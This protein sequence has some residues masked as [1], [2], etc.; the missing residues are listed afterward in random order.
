MLI[1]RCVGVDVKDYCSVCDAEISRESKTI[2]AKGHTSSDWITDKAATC[3]ETG[4]RHKE[5][6]VCG[7]ILDTETVAKLTTHTPATAVT[8]NRVDATCTKAGSYDSVVYCSVC[9]AEISRE[10]KTIAKKA[11]TSSDWITDKEP[12]YTEAGSRH[13]ECTVCGEILDTETMNPLE[14]THAFGEWSVSKV[15]TCT[16]AG[17]KV[18]VCVC[19]QKETEA[20]AAKGHTSSDWITDKQPTCKEAGSRHTECTVCGAVLKT[21]TVAK[22]TTHPPAAAVTENRVDAT[23]T[24]AGS[25]DSVIY[26][27]VCDAE[28]SRESKTIAKKEHTP[29]DWMVDKAATCKEAGSRHTECTVCEAVLKTESI[30]KLTTHTP[31]TAVTENKVD[32]TCTKAGSY[33]SVIYC[34]VCDAEISRESKTIA[35]KAHTPSDWITDKAATCKETGSRHTE[36]TVCGEILDT[37]T[38][39]KLTTHTPATAVTENRVDATCTKAG[40]YDSVVY[41]SVCD[42]E[43]SRE[44]KT[45]AKKAHTSSGWITD[46]EPTYTEAGARH[47]ECTVCKT[48]LESGTIAKLDP[49]VYTVNYTVG[50]QSGSVDV[51]IIDSFTLPVV[52][53]EGYTFLGYYDGS[54]QITDGE[55]KKLASYTLTSDISI[56]AKYRRIAAE[57]PYHGECVGNPGKAYYS[58][59]SFAYKMARNPWDMILYNGKLYV[60]GGYLDVSWI[61]SPPLSSYDTGTNA[62]SYTDFDVKMYEAFDEDSTAKAW[63]DLPAASSS[64]TV[65][66]GSIK[67][68]PVSTDKEIAGFRWIGGKPFAIGSD[69]LGGYTWADGTLDQKTPSEVDASDTQ[70][71]IANTSGNY[72]AVETDESGNDVW[73]EYRNSIMHGTQVYDVIEIDYNGERTLMF[74]VGTGGLQLPVKILSSKATKSYLTPKFYLADGTQ[75]SGSS[76]NRVYHFFKTDEGIFAFYSSQDGTVNKIFKYSVVGNEHRFDEVRDVT[77]GATSADMRVYLQSDVDKNGT[78]IADRR[79]FTDYMRTETYGGYA[80]YTTGYLYKTKTFKESETAAI[81][82]PGGAIITDLLVKDGTLYVLGFKETDVGSAYTNYVWSLG[83]D[84]T[85]TEVRSFTSEGAYALS[86]EKDG[87][88]F[89]VGLGGPSTHIT[90]DVTSVG[91]IVRLAA[92]EHPHTFGEWSTDK[93]ATCTEAG[94]RVR[95]CECGKQEIEVIPMSGHTS[96]G[97][98][99]DKAATCKEAGSRHTECTVC[100]A[101]LK[102]ESI[103]KLTTHTPATAVTENKVDATCTK[104]GSYDSVIYCSVCDAEISRESKTIAKKAHTSSGWITD[105]DPTYTEEG[106]RHKECT[107]C[108]T[109]LESESIPKL[110]AATYT[111]SYSAATHRGEITVSTV[112]SF[113]LPVIP[114]S[115]YTFLGYYEGDVQVTD[116]T[117]KKLASYTLTSDVTLTA[118]YTRLAGDADANGE[119]LGN[120][121]EAYYKSTSFTHKMARNPWDMA[122][123]NGKLY[124]SGGYYGGAW[125]SSPPIYTYDTFAG[126]WGYADFTVKMYEALDADSTAKAWH[127]LNATSSS[128]DNVVGGIKGIPVTTDCEIS[129]FKW[130]DGKLFAL[131]ADTINGNTWADGTVSS[132]LPTDVDANDTQKSVPNNLGNYYTVETDESGNDVWVEY[133]NNILHGTHVYDVIEIDYNGGKA[134]MFAVGTSGTPMP[135]K[136]LTNPATKSYLSPKFYLK[137]GTVYSGN[138]N[139]RVYNFFKTDE[140]IFAFYAHQGGTDKK[141]FKYNVVNG[142]HRFDEVRDI[143]IN[144]TTSDTANYQQSDVNSSGTAISTRRLYTDFMKTESYNGYAYYTT[145]YLYKTKT[146]VKSETTKIAAPNGAIITDLLVRDGVLYALGFKKTNSTTNAYTNYVW[147]L[148]SKDAFTEIRSF[149]STGAYALSFEKDEDFFYVGL[150]GPTTHITT[151]ATSVGD[152]VRLAID[153]I[154]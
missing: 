40:S 62:W 126:E 86:F 93:A 3:K 44:S 105:K 115:G 133:R 66:A 65:V 147:S 75:Y 48:V 20:I 36:C 110:V 84:D 81:T 108:K 24:K 70:K 57:V 60:G 8:E 18:R 19:G 51:S 113:T 52:A 11:H 104:A 120:P 146:F 21:E 32:A 97:W 49:P 121:G 135:V 10:S 17:V 77:L 131:G 145:G 71:Y 151:T 117:G 128:S 123:L 132:K 4:S 76:K 25:Y 55:G 5:C 90:A 38:V 63:Y 139:N 154:N 13:K 74:A 103:A 41:C 78:V 59:T 6:T 1:E 33:D 100:G 85:F 148:D 9:D 31:A 69:N 134:L 28:I 101:V 111:V 16:E 39:A 14:H 83:V 15:A 34:S 94:R 54:V 109:V 35:K 119:Y 99:T 122:L 50:G 37:E 67:G 92:N 125:I 2:A 29:S 91:D 114:R 87:E 107:V 144:A 136:I 30:A 138:S 127:T 89:Y 150:G 79:L 42:A 116:A 56:A 98:I 80:Y 23:C 27:S 12:T 58:G 95:E 152:I 124:V 61:P 130:I 102:T 68:I 143:T 7:E 82:A 72:Y 140:G 46:K 22:L 149:T 112:D 153:P 96:S 43:I 141:I 137:D 106:A 118:K 142:E 47:K 73:V 26:C 53:M 64:S 45:I 88:F 129:S